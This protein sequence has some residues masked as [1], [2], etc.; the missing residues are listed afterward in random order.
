MKIFTLKPNESWIVDRMTDEWNQYNADIITKDVNQADVIWLLADWAYNQLPYE[1]LKQKK[2][3]TTIHHITHAKFDAAA[4]A[5]FARRDAITDAYHVFNERTQKYIEP[6]TTKP[7]HLIPYWANQ[8]QWVR[9]DLTRE[10][11]RRK[12][13][14][15]VGDILLGSF[16]RDTEGAGI[17]QGIYLPKL[18]KG[19]DLFVEAVKHYVI[20]NSILRWTKKI[21]V[22]LAG[23]RRQYVIQELKKE[24]I[25]YTYF[26]NP[27]LEQV[28]ELYQTL[29][30]YLVCSREEGGPQSLIEAGL[31]GVPVISRP[32]GIAEQVLPA[33]SIADKLWDGRESIPNVD[34]M[35]L[36]G[37]F[38][39]YRKLFKSL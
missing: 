26:E 21:H 16:Q 13:N 38:G 15:P 7:I 12:Y 36:P 8:N 30:K 10:D 28:G 11:L 39:P 14:L 18:E 9:S 24:K 6:L 32:V 27:P 23:W 3:V 31:L 22:V 20:Q 4:R 19:P 2:V 34:S 29:S 5:D 33:I 25:N 17:P 1:L 35:K 37:A